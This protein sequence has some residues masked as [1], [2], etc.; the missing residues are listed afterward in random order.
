[1]KTTI[2]KELNENGQG[3]FQI[4]GNS[5]E[6]ILHSRQSTILLQKEEQYQRYDVVLFRRP[7]TG[8]YVLHRIVK[9][10]DQYHFGICGDNCIFVEKVPKSWILGRMTGWYPGTEETFIS[11]DDRNYLQ[12]VRKWKI[13]FIKRWIK[14][15]PKRVRRKLIGNIRE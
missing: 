12:Y 11:C 13:L 3:Y 6:P 10:I 8:K 4:V 15:F 5:M 7:E 2:E 9:E 1:M 14:A